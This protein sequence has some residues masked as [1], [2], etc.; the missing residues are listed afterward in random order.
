MSISKNRFVVEI[1][2]IGF[3]LFSNDKYIISFIKTNYLKF[4]GS[5]KDRKIAAS[6]RILSYSLIQNA[7]YKLLNIIRCKNI[8]E[9]TFESS[10]KYILKKR[11]GKTEFR[12]LLPKYY[13]DEAFDNILRIILSSV[14]LKQNM[15]LLHASSVIRNGKVTMFIGKSGAGKSTIAALSGYEMFHDDLVL[16]KKNENAKYTFS[17][18][19]FKPPYIKKEFKGE[20]D[21]IYYIWKDTSNFIKELTPDTQLCYLLQSVWSFDEFGIVDDYNDRIMAFCKDILKVTKLSDL[22]FTKTN[23]FVK[24]L[25][26]RT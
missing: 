11:N 18:I 5:K 9:K 13:R 12:I 26:S 15:I 2:D 19:P 23:H 8:G 6:F 21:N 14:C 3:E 16:L 22:H 25:Q 10:F 20:I 1:Q 17:T 24:L 4:L 7:Y